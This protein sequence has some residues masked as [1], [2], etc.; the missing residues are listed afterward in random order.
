MP[1]TTIQEE[2]SKETYCICMIED[3]N[4]TFVIDFLKSNNMKHVVDMVA[5]AWDEIEA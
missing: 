4:G 3:E 1:E 5:E 2:A